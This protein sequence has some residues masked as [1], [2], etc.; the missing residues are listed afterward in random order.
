MSKPNTPTY[1]TSNRAAYNKA[2]KR[3]GS[4]TVWL[5]PAIM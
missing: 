3:L 1:K 4:L 5:E 2:L